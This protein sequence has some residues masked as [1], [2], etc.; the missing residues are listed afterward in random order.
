[1]HA[2]NNGTTGLCK[3]L[4]GNGSV[5]TL[6]AGAMPSHPNSANYDMTS[7]FCV[8]CPKLIIT[9]P[10]F[11]KIVHIVTTGLWR[12]KM[13]QPDLYSEDP[14]FESWPVYSL[15]RIFLT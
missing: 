5:N 11:V 2:R 7:V 4:L 15:D 6:R 14:R 3:P 8:V 12:V 9:K 10:Y 1:M 13:V